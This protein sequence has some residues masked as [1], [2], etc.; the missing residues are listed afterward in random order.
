V[1]AHLL[2]KALSL[3]AVVVLLM[4]GVGRIRDIA[5]ERAMYR[6][7]AVE[8]VRKSLAGS[9]TIAGIVIT[10]ACTETVQTTTE[11]AKGKTVE[12]SERSS[13]L[14]ALPQSVKWSSQSTIEPRYRGLYKVNSFNLSAKALVQ[15]SDIAE[16]TP[17]SLRDN[18][19]AVVCSE[20]RAEFSVSD[21]RGIRS[22]KLTYGTQTLKPE[23]IVEGGA[24]RVGFAAKLSV[25]DAS[26]KDAVQLNLDMDLVGTES[27]SFVPLGNENLV[28]I[29][30]S[31]PHPSFGG[32]FLPLERSVRD[33]GFVAKWS[34]SSLASTARSQLLRGASPCAGIGEGSE[35]IEV[36]AHR[37]EYPANQ[38]TQP[39][40]ANSV[41]CLQSFGVSFIDPIN[42]SSLSDR[43]TKYAFLFIAL[44]FVGIV[45]L[46]VMK[47]ARVHPIQYF[48]IGAA[49]AAFFLLLISL[50]E[51]VSFVVAYA[52]AALACV[53]LIGV[54]AKAVL[55][56]W[57][58][59]LP[60]MTGLAALYGVLYVVL[61]S[62]QHALL[63]GS[64][65]IFASL[66]A[67]M[68]LT[69]DVQWHQ[70]SERL[71]SK[72]SLS[73]TSDASI[74]ASTVDTQIQT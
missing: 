25:A 17:P 15:W 44:T 1:K 42:P 27:L 31:W 9:Q 66:A 23:A 2:L 32:S 48:L 43:A 53:A 65:M 18:V 60:T 72:S 49:L 26:L 58:R 35:N 5:S 61:Q 67:V 74:S 33:D 8:S 50:S 40:A 47:G 64:L 14:R 59:A 69:R 70:I 20:P 62:E 13:I 21:A 36:G 46:E 51:H 11:T 16:L 3:F 12:K 73:K 57:S 7:H 37:S 71:A 34:V 56:G 30:S 45:L 19:V 38:A 55:G 22:I 52:V 39:A 4:F 28:E 63:A 54:Y 6:Q 10:R 68:L 29:N 24:F 41:G